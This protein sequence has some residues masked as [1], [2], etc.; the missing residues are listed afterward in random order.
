MA[1][2]R[3]DG[4]EV[5][6]THEFLSMMLGTRRASVTDALHLLEGHEIISTKRSCISILDRARLE[7]I[8]GDC[9]GLPESELA[10][11]GLKRKDP[12]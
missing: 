3:I 6:L 11:V 9:Y 7:E 12:P 2:D 8:A 4:D 10:R 5:P 1:Q